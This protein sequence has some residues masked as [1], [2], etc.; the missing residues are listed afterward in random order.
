[1]AG[2]KWQQ[3]LHPDDQATFLD[4]FRESLRVHGRLEATVRFVRSDGEIVPALVRCEPVAPK[5]AFHG[6]AG[7]WE[8]LV[9]G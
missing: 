9:A 3:A 5:G 8:P 2:L 4:R 1:M 6:M 7:D